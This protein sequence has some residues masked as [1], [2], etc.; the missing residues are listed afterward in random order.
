MS[1]VFYEY[2]SVNAFFEVESGD[3]QYQTLST[4]LGTNRNCS[5]CDR[6]F[7]VFDHEY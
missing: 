7:L 2:R 3:Q 6:Y 5:N 4:D 1:K